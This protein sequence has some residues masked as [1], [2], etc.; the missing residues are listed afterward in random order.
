MKIWEPEHSPSFELHASAGNSELMTGRDYHTGPVCCGGGRVP[1][2][3]SLIGLELAMLRSDWSLRPECLLGICW[4]E[5]E[6]G[7]YDLGHRC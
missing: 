3:W 5:W 6:L 7:D 1:E 2:C 4:A